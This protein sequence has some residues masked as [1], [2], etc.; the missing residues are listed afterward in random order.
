LTDL[1]AMK[2]PFQ[3]T[4]LG[5][6]FIIVGIL[7]TAYHFWERSTW[8]PRGPFGRLQYWRV[9]R[10]VDPNGCAFISRR[11]ATVDTAHGKAPILEVSVLQSR[12]E[13]MLPLGCEPEDLLAGCCR[14][15]LREPQRAASLVLAG[16]VPF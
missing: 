15:N 14:H 12:C 8:L 10:N 1:N 16:R 5:W 9:E 11:V 2:R 6:L 13:Q 4:V 7:S 3:V